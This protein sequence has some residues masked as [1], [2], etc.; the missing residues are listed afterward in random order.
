MPAIFILVGIFRQ[1]A[2][3]ICSQLFLISMACWVFYT[4]RLR[5]WGLSDQ[6][7]LLVGCR[8]WGHRAG[9][10]AYP[11][12][13]QEKKTAGKIRMPLDV[14]LPPSH[15]T[16]GI[17]P[18]VGT[19]TW[20]WAVEATHIWTHTHT[21]LVRGKGVMDQCWWVATYEKCVFLFP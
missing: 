6:N 7:W 16:L 9:T 8:P 12:L 21:P 5:A 4:P 10:Q 19:S 1:N 17:S 15:L 2:E 20:P 14:I 11:V 3:Q 13:Q 18:S